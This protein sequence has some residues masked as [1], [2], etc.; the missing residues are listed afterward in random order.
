MD[1]TKFASTAEVRRRLAISHVHFV[2]N[3][4]NAGKTTVSHAVLD[5]LRKQN[6]S[7]G[8]IKPVATT[9]YDH[10]VIKVEYKLDNAPADLNPIRIE[11]KTTSD[12]IMGSDV[13]RA[14]ILNERKLKI[15][16]AYSRIAQDKDFVVVEGTGHSAVGYC[17]DLSNAVVA[18]LLNS[19]LI[20]I[21]DGGIGKTVDLS[22]LHLEYFKQKRSHILGV[23]INRVEPDTWEKIGPPLE[24]NFGRLGTNILGYVYYNPV[25]A[26]ATAREINDAIEK[27]SHLSEF[28]DAS[29]LNSGFLGGTINKPILGTMKL[30][31]IRNSFQE[32]GAVAIVPSHKEQLI[33]RIASLR[34]DRIVKQPAAMVI[35]GSENVSRDPLSRIIN[36]APFPIWRTPHAKIETIYKLVDDAIHEGNH[37]IDREDRQKLSIIHNMVAEH[38]D[39]DKI[40]QDSKKFTSYILWP[41]PSIQFPLPFDSEFMEQEAL[42]P[43]LI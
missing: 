28:M 1:I 38:V 3:R 41:Y 2:G 13:E 42:T 40:Y 43:I 11:R 30:N 34:S 37:K 32:E 20:F 17:I 36:E 23:I 33:T 27:K 15:M 4:Q 8:Y 39:I 5:Y 6:L 31:E 21:V 35:V 10:M 7:V 29:F 14:R 16:D 22:A 25:L 9:S 24:R 12:Y 18:N 19:P 26:A